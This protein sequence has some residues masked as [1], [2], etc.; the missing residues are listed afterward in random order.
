[1]ANKYRNG[2]L[3]AGFGTLQQLVTLVFGLIV[4]RLFIQT[5]GSEMNGLLSSLGNLYSYLALVEA[6]VGTVAIQALYGPVGRNDK[7]SI[8]EIMTAT[9]NYY[10]KAG[11]M[12]LVGVIAIAIIYPLTVTTTIPW[13]TIV[14]LVF[15]NGIGG[16]INFW[17]QGKYLVLL[18]A[19]GKKYLMSIVTMLIYIAQNIVKIVL[20][21][22]GFDVIA[23]HIGYFIIS[24]CQ[25]GF[26]FYY[27]RRNYKWL[28]LHSVPNKAALSQSNAVLVQQITWMICSNT[29]ILDAYQN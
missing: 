12:Y 24:L 26:Y 27:M 13:T 20:L 3:S 15:L 4:P 1:M 21:L 14:L 8:N 9:S 19:E 25:M 11:F 5:F 16:V 22:Q 18:Q 23:I 10:N 29:D 6:G 7:K 2:I 28:D 17:V